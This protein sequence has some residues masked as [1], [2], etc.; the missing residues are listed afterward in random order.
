MYVLFIPKRKFDL[1]KSYNLPLNDLV[2]S[3][4]IRSTDECLLYEIDI[5]SCGLHVFVD[6]LCLHF[7]FDCYN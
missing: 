3:F 2:L 1:H 6:G 5:L 4:A 7:P